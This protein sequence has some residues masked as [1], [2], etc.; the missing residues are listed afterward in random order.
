MDIKLI[1]RKKKGSTKSFP[2]P[3]SV[4]VIGR[5]HNCDL[6]VPLM[7]VS[8][9]HCQLNHDEGVL[10][11]RDL[12]SRNGTVLNG[13]KIEEAVVQPG[14][15]LKI[16]PVEFIIQVNGQPQQVISEAAT[17]KNIPAKEKQANNDEDTTE[18]PFDSF[19]ELDLDDIEPLDELES[20]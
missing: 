6:C 4:T 13:K 18:E 16:G 14:D 8:K 9:R 20:I 7:S 3:S 17:A 19:E 10:K 2:L 11:I 12:G 15:S 1:L 5:R